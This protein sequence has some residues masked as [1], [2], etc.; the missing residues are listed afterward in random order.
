[1]HE[2]WSEEHRCIKRI[3]WPN[4]LD[5]NGPPPKVL[6]TLSRMPKPTMWT[7]AYKPKTGRRRKQRS[8]ASVTLKKLKERR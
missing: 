4:L 8:Q 5:L 3:L 7:A 2:L 6:D 1:M